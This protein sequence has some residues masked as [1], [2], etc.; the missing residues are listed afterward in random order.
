MVFFFHFREEGT[1]FYI[2]NQENEVRAFCICLDLS[3]DHFG[4]S[5]SPIALAL[6]TVHST[7]ASSFC[8]GSRLRMTRCLSWLT[9]VGH[10]RHPGPLSPPYSLYREHHVRKP[11][12]L[13]L[14]KLVRS[15]QISKES[16]TTLWCLWAFSLQESPL[17]RH[18]ALSSVL[19]FMSPHLL[20]PSLWVKPTTAATQ[21]QGIRLPRSPAKLFPCRGWCEQQVGG[22]S[23]QQ[24][25]V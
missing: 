15:S 1:D 10:D 13:T 24:T 7:K 3:L 2:N 16:V 8:P 20:F 19:R 22:V 11:Q 18:A 23:S 5:Q 25:V 6:C 17:T 9:L 21:G 14:P 12:E 4:S